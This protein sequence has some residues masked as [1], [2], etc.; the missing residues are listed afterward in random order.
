MEAVRELERQFVIARG[1]V[2]HRFRF[3]FP[4]MLVRIVGRNDLTCRKKIVVD[5]DMVMSGAFN[6]LA[7]R[8][9]FHTFYPHHYLYRSLDLRKV[10]ST[11]GLLLSAS[12]E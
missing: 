4:E 9:D 6:N 5:Q 2:Q 7:G 8:L 3:A 11:L 12:N 1:Q 10:H